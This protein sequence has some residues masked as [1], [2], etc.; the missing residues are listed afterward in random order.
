[1]NS[2]RCKMNW[3]WHRKITPLDFLYF[4]QQHVNFYSLEQFHTRWSHQVCG[5]RGDRNASNYFII[6]ST[7]AASHSSSEI[8]LN[9]RW[10]IFFTR[11]GLFGDKVDQQLIRCI[12]INS[13]LDVFHI[14]YG[15]GKEEVALSGC[16]SFQLKFNGSDR[17]SCYILPLL[18][19][20]SLGLSY[21]RM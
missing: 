18:W 8:Q 12:P 4:K 5:I 17:T 21:I 9:T 13:C 15:K 1:M 7:E 16:F 11:K 6:C 3:T 10:I 20:Y 19:N 2:V 14:F